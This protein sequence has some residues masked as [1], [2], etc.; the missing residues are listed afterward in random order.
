LDNQQF[1]D[2]AK[3]KINKNPVQNISTKSTRK[4]EF[5]M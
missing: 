4:Q 1:A 3:P 2:L 5:A